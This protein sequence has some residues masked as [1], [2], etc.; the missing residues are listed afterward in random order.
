[1]MN[2]KGVEILPITVADGKIVKTKAYP[3]NDEIISL[4]QVPRSY[5]GEQKRTTPPKS[6][7]CDCKGGYYG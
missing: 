3:T 7:G 2:E 5:L 6:G 1:M 4:L